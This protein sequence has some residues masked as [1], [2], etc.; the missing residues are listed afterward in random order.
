MRGDVRKMSPAPMSPRLSH[1]TCCFQIVVTNVGTSVWPAEYRVASPY[2][3]SATTDTNSPLSSWRTRD[4][5][6][7]RNDGRKGVGQHR[8]LERRG[9]G[10]VGQRDP[11]L[12]RR[13][14]VDAE[15]MR[16]RPG[17]ERRDRGS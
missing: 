10:I 8:N 2:S 1:T 6:V 12:R 13:L 3:A 9:R 15:V 4:S 7:D 17:H 5:T 16:D 11:Q 14:L